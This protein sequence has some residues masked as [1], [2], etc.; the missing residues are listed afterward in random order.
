MKGKKNIA[1]TLQEAKEWYKGDNSTLKEL[2]LKAF[3]KEELEIQELPKT[4]KEFCEGNPIQHG[5]CFI[6]PR[7]NIESLGDDDCRHDCL[8]RNVCISESEAKAFLALMQLRQLRKAYVKD[9]EPDWGCAHDNYCIIICQRTLVIRPR[10]AVSHPFS[11]PTY[12]LAEQFLDNFC[13]LLEIAKP[14]L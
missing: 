13:Y 8:D 3:S 11:F 1:I 6:N 12:E 5:E 9:W 2:A 10:S 4:W 14:L 7:S